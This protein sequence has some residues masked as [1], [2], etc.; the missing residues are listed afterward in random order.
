MSLPTPPAGTLD[1]DQ[2]WY[3]GRISDAQWDRLKAKL[4]GGRDA[5]GTTYSRIIDC[6][7]AEADK[8]ISNMKKDPRGY[9][10]INMPGGAEG[11]EN[12]YNYY[13]F[14]KDAYLYD[15]PKPEP[16][17]IPVEVEVVEVEQ[18]T[19]DE[20]IVIKIEAP[21]EPAPEQKRQAPKR[22]RLPRRSGLMKARP[23][24]PPK[25]SV[26]TRMAEAFDSRL[27][28]LVDTIQNPPAPAPQKQRKQKESLVKIRSAVKPKSKFKEGKN[29]KPF[30]NTSLFVF[31]KVKGAFK[32]AAD[33]RKMAQEQ[34]LPEQE[35]G[36][37][38]TR[39]L[40]FEFGGDAIARTKGTFSRSPDATLDP[41]LSK[42]ERY[43]QGLFGTRTIR[44]PKQQ[45][46]EGDINII[47]KQIA[48]IDKK[49]DGIIKTK[50]EKSE[51]QT[52]TL[53]NVLEELK[54]KLQSGNKLQ[55]DIND[56]KK[57]LLAA[58]AKAADQ[59]QSAAEEAEIDQSKD[60]SDFED[61]YES[62]EETGGGEGEEDDGDG[63]LDIDWKK[64]KA[65]KWLRRLRNPG[66]FAR[67]LGRLTRMRV[68][69]F[70]R[71]A[72]QIGSRLATGAKGLVTGGA[73]ASAAIVLGVGAAASGIGEGLFQLTKKGGAGEQTRDALK[74]K[75]E[76]IG[77]PMGSL[78]GGVGNLAGFS[79]EATKV[80]GNAL[81]AIGTP[82]RY[83]IEGIRYPFLNEKDREKQAHNLSKFDARIREYSR[84]WMNRI[85]FMN[86]VP[87]E[88][89]G[90]GNI[91]G[92]NDAQK[93]MMEKMSEGGTI[94]EP[95]FQGIS[96]ARLTGDLP[97]AG[98]KVMVGEAGDEM[99]T[100]PESNPLQSLAPMIVAMREVTKRAGTWADPVEN[101]VR[102]ITDP[103][104][105][106]IG[107]P[108]LPTT[109]EIGQNIPDGEQG[110]QGD[111]LKD[112]KKGLFGNLM[113]FL[114]GNNSSSTAT[115]G[116][117]VTPF[118]GDVDMG[119]GAGRTTAGAVYNYL[120]SKGMSE[121]HAKGITANISRESGFK[122]GAH[123]PND[124]GAGS[125]GLF[126]WNAGRATRMMA[127]VP[128]WK[129]NWQAQIDYALG[130]D[131]GPRFL[132]TQFGSAGEAAY[133]W[134][135]YW[136]RP[137][138]SVQAKYTPAAYEGMI[139]KMGL[140]RGM[141]V[142][143]PAP[144]AAP[145]TPASENQAGTTASGNRQM[146]RAA[147]K[148][149]QEVAR[150]AT[151]PAVPPVAP[152][153]A[154]SSTGTVVIPALFQVPGAAAQQPAA[155]ASQGVVT[156]TVGIDWTK[157]LRT[158]RLAGS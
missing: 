147:S 151:Q 88:K 121:N 158:Q 69:R 84:G 117:G 35:E 63:G 39:A 43:T 49:F 81:D 134:M 94:P 59:A 32:R 37:Y 115:T 5:G 6:S 45:K 36:Y 129:T 55:K 18:K 40:G 27:D 67:S 98:P 156:P 30:E 22:I 24:G 114:K 130:E 126:Q 137:A 9:P 157:A 11:Y 57:K 58:E 50:S 119:G 48:E 42:Q 12:M 14:L 153:A 82:I 111:G 95:K 100:T 64:F 116:P 41:A 155:A 103:I 145:P 4:T 1:K 33:A 38:V 141:P 143:P 93:D 21:F 133:D 83:A 124:P 89:G 104:A 73:A 139:Q 131:H 146:G 112:K 136:E 71:P 44:P 29:V 127:A 140:H 125:F 107:L 52:D 106:K 108:T 120:L 154:S 148:R 74:K 75:G 97:T 3:R 138:E 96:G 87:D 110:E 152:A 78:I 23:I 17:E 25:K 34:G 79:T 66:R 90:F 20:P 105:K 86:V 142:A 46:E 85:D 135:K 16:E 8:I 77:G 80:T 70:L 65:K 113:D 54:R 60:L 61:M 19:V 128:D 53:E 56:K 51:G 99:V 31:N 68:G 91:Y 15:E 122:L 28:D 2:P 47:T 144:P 10:Q 62:P 7:D 150:A 109:I 72:G 102:Q 92:N 132:S 76:E 123:N 13:T 26:A 101:M 118:N 149:R